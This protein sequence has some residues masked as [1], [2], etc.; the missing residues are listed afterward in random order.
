MKLPRRS[1]ID[2]ETQSVSRGAVSIDVEMARRHGWSDK[3]ILRAF[4]AVSAI[5][6]KEYALSHRN[7]PVKNCPCVVCDPGVA[8]DLTDHPKCR[9]AWRRRGLW[10][11]RGKQPQKVKH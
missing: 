4:E 6:A 9:A 8:D 10:P 1:F 5:A 3:A 2:D 7:G 11:V